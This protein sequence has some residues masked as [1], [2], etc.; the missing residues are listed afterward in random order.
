[1]QLSADQQRAAEIIVDRV[2]ARERVTVLTGWAG[3]GKT[4]VLRALL[5]EYSRPALLAPTGKSAL[6]MSEVTGYP[7]STIHSAL[8]DTAYR[9]ESTGTLGFRWLPTGMGCPGADVVFVDEIS[10][11][12]DLLFAHLL[13]IIPPRIP[14]VGM[15]DPAQ[16][17]TIRGRWGFPLLTPHARLETIHRQ[18]SGSAILRLATA[19]RT[20]RRAP[21][22]AMAR[23]AG[24]P[25][26][27]TRPG[28]LPARLAEGVR[29]GRDSAY[30]IDK[31]DRR[32]SLC[33]A[34]RAELGHA[35][36]A[37]PQPGERVMVL[38][39]RH[40]MGV[41]N[42]EVCDVLDSGPARRAPGFAAVTLRTALGREIEAHVCLAAWQRQEKL[43]DAEQRRAHRLRLATALDLCPAYA[44]TVH[45]A[46]GSEWSGVGADW[47]AGA[48]M[49]E[50]RW[51]WAYTLATRA[52]DRL[53]YLEPS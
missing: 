52:R 31:N 13:R 47:G 15:G 11:V 30:L 35:P 25:V 10:M 36:D 20:Q 41:C 29:E 12:D 21:T 40:E 53:A 51:R 50:N 24:V 8:I 38:R 26:Y 18:A 19:I 33:A 14:I 28:W 23:A 17:P 43:N 39:N 6:R 48:F 7:A 5:P 9:D 44:I 37:P 1:M 22:L 4:T 46:Q 2:A 49:R 27:R 3:T 16:L 34:V 45:K 42:G 32:T